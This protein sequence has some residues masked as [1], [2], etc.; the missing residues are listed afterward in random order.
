MQGVDRF[1]QAIADAGLEP[2]AEIIPD[3]KIHRFASSG[4]RGDAAG[5]YVLHT[6]DPPAGAFGCWR[7]GISETW[8]ARDKAH[9]SEAER[10][11]FRE[12]VQAARKEADRLRQQAQERAAEEARRRWEAAEPADPGH[13]YLQAKGIQ[14]HGLRQEGSYL[15]VP[16]RGITGEWQSLQTIGPDGAKRFLPGGKVAGGAHWLGK[17]RDGAPVL[18]CEGFATAAS[19]HEA[20]GHLVVVAFNAGNL[21]PVAKAV[22][23]KLPDARLIIA[24][25]NDYA[26]DGNPGLTKAKEAA[27]A[28]N[29]ALCWPEGI[30]GTD[31]NDLHQERGLAAVRATVDSAEPVED[32]AGEEPETLAQ[33]VERLAALPVLEYE[34]R[35]EQEARRLKVR[36]GVLDAEVTKARRA[37]EKEAGSDALVEEAEPWPEPVAGGEL[38]GEIRALLERHAVLPPGAATAITLWLLGT[39][40]HD[41][42][43][44]FP[45]LLITSPEMR[46]GKTTVL[47]LIG[48]VAARSMLVSNITP[49]AIFRT[50]EAARPTLLIDEADT[51]LGN[52]DELR[53]VI[54]SGHTR[55][56][57]FVIRTVGD[58]HTPRKFSTWAPMA[59]A[60]IRRPAGTIIDRSIVI[61]LRRKLPGERVERLPL[62][63]EAG[64]LPLRQRLARWA[65]D[66][67][68][69]LRRARPEL[70][71]CNN[72]RALDNW[73]PLLAIADAIGWRSEAIEAFGV[74][75]AADDDESAG[76]LLLEDVRAY[77]DER[78]GVERVHSIDL[79]DWLT[80]LEERPWGEWK[81]GKPM[82][83]NTLAKM[84]KPYGVKSRQIRIGMENRH[85]Y[86]K[87]DFEDAWRRYTPLPPAPP[88]EQNATT[89]QANDGAGFRPIQNATQEEDVAFRNRRKA[90]AG[91]GCSVVAFQNEG[92]QGEGGDPPFETRAVL[93]GE[94]G[95]TIEIVEG[96]A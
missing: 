7:E 42:F 4:K 94:D 84:L 45:K 75:G 9:L 65:Q 57:A 83:T 20:T 66:S 79:V 19:L 13:P 82:T 90:S 21:L 80:D 2:P 15:L 93:K 48:A 76:P 68:E 71:A 12:R 88:P 10:Q 72:D 1:R 17:R 63:L 36:V 78:P 43:G 89:L 49:A 41:A 67:M 59:I 58:D 11:A 8:C 51:F 37:M 26:T 39:W 22:R 18:L 46:C 86:R 74:L 44:I 30:S 95:E 31:F 70:P 33:A 61:E 81:R 54:N 23:E 25:D 40:T 27:R 35:R 96:E 6:D 29:A 5:W 53:G 50:I 92:A 38:A 77:F 60:M 91:A 28:V 62:D 56:G 55:S 47:S 69:A 52:N 3:G 32:E 85:G 14:P 16:V 24:A 34:Q 73:T 64:S 87:R